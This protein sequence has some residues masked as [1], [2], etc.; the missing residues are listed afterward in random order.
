MANQALRKAELL[1][2]W[3]GPAAPFPAFKWW[4]SPDKSYRHTRRPAYA[5]QGIDTIVIH[6]TA[7]GSSAGAMSVTQKGTASW[8]LLVP[9]ED[10]P[11]HGEYAYRCVPDSGAAWHVLSKC[12][13]PADGRTNINDRSMGVEVVNWQDGKDTFSDWQLRITA[14]WVRYCWS[15]LGCKYLYTHAFLDPG[16]KSDPGGMFD[17]DKFMSYVLEMYTVEADREPLSVSVDGKPVDVGAWLD[18]GVTYAPIAR[19]ARAC[20]AAV[21]WNPK[22]KRVEITTKGGA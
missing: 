6:A 15:V 13:H 22:T 19:V 18:K 10:E 20:G 5:P 8:H 9:D 3:K 12:K 1:P 17:W 16:R 11:G 7:G 14:Q 2:E 4:R 21:A